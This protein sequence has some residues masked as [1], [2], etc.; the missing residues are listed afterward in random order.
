MCC[1]KYENET[2]QVLRKGMPDIGDRVVT[3]DGMGVVIDSNT[4]MSQIKT[5]LVLEE[6]TADSPEK[7]STEFYFYKKAEIKKIIGKKR[8]RVK[9]DE[10][11]ATIDVLPEEIKDLLKE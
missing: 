11:E 10:F 5:R 2:Y 7:L 8:K 3:S 1:L 4:L 6:K 9:E